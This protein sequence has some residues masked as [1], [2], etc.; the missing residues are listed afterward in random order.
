MSYWQDL[1]D[2]PDVFVCVLIDEVESLTAARKAGT[3][4]LSVCLSVS[5]KTAYIYIYTHIHIK[6]IRSTRSL[7]NLLKLTQLTQGIASRRA[8]SPVGNF[9]FR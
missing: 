2:D 9:A 3:T 5:M 4:V 1:L 8:T 6:H 7:E